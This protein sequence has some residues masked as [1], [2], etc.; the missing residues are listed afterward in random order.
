M[1]LIHVVSCRLDIGLLKNED[2]G[3]CVRAVGGWPNE[4]VE[5]T[6][7]SFCPDKIN[8]KLDLLKLGKDWS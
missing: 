1:A 4:G 6:Y 8:A 2:T 7:S 3:Q 5:L